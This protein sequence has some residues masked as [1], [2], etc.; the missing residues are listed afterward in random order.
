MVISIGGLI[1]VMLSGVTVSYEIIKGCGTIVVT[2][3]ILTD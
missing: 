3:Y 2:V 1:S